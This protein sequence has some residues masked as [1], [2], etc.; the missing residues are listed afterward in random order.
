MKDRKLKGVLKRLDAE[1]E[2]FDVVG[3]TMVKEE[4]NKSVRGD[5]MLWFYQR[6]YP[7]NTKEYVLASLHCAKTAKYLMDMHAEAAFQALFIAKAFAE[8]KVDRYILDSSRRSVANE[9]H[10]ACNCESLYPALCAAEAA[11]DTDY[12]RWIHNSASFS[13]IAIYNQIEHRGQCPPDYEGYAH[14]QRVINRAK[15]AMKENQ[16]ETADI[17]RKYLTITNYD[18]LQYL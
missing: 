18:F 8:G 17:C 12:H 11:V 13:A 15:K 2:M 5:W 6:L 3:N 10:S 7:G 14:K 4:W 9:A 16:K 1:K